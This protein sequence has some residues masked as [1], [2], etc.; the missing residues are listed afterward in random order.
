MPGFPPGYTPYL[1]LSTIGVNGQ[2]VDQ[3]AYP[4]MCQP[5][6][7]SPGYY[8]ASLPFGKLAPSPYMWDPSLLVGD[9]LFG[10]NYAGIPE[11][12]VPKHNLSSPSNTHSPLSKSFTE[13]TKLFD[14]NSYLPSLCLVRSRQSQTPK[15]GEQGSLVIVG[16]YVLF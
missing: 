3:Q 12:P 2:Y 6:T 15:T 14:I 8:P 9:G 4:P 13:F 10:N 16:I 1:P 5:P 7:A 11:F